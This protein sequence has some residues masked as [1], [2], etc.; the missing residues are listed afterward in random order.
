MELQRKYGWRR[1]AP[2]RYESTHLRVERNGK[3]D[4][5][6]WWVV[7]RK[8]NDRLLIR[9]TSLRRAK[10]FALTNEHLAALQAKRDEED[11]VHES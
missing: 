3:G 5:R 2:G 10:V 6:T 7:W 8:D 4:G 11:N 9:E 1:L